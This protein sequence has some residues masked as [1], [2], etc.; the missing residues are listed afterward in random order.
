MS[1]RYIEMPV[2]DFGTVFVEISSTEGLR[3]VSAGELVEKAKDAFSSISHTIEICAKGF[4]SQIRKLGEYSPQEVSIEFGI[5]LS[6]EVG[7]VVAN[8]TTEGSYKVVLT[9]K[10]T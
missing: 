7:A 9:W 2:D 6:T 10:E 1:T 4:I 3:E 8:M 5:S